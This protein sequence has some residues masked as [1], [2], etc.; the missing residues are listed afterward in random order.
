[1]AALSQTAANVI[2]TGTRKSGTSGGTV[3]AGMP[4]YRDT[5]DENKLK[6]ARA[7]ALTTAACI[8]VALNS[9]SAGQPLSYQE[10]GGIN[11]GA[12]LAVGETY[13]V[14]DATAGQIVPVADLGTGDYVTILGVAT[15]TSNLALG[16]ITS[17]VAKG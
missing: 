14:S 9:A 8:G 10:T 1:M 12:T 11:L 2:G 13:C 17:G 6:A 5:A 7:N 16:I 4:L 15:T 3:T